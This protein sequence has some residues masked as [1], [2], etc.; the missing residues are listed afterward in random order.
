MMRMRLLMRFKE[1]A[2]CAYMFLSHSPLIQVVLA[3]GTIEWYYGIFSLS[4]ISPFNLP[5]FKGAFSIE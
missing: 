3:S 5:R 4:L 2:I 1:A